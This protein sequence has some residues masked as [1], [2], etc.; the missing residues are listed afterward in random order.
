MATGRIDS[1]SSRSGK[2]FF[3][4]GENIVT[5]ALDGLLHASGPGERVR[6]DG[7]PRIKVILRGD[8]K[9]DRVAVISGGWAGHEPA[10]AGFVGAGMLTAAVSGEIFAS[11]QVEAILA[12]ILSVTGEPGCLVIVKNYTGDRLNFGLAVERAKSLGKNVA[13]VI[14]SDDVAIPGTR[15]PQESPA[16]CSSISLPAIL[17]NRGV[18]LRMSGRRRK[19][20]RVAPG[21]LGFPFPPAACRGI[22]SISG[23][24]ET[25]RS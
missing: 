20:S 16:P 17:L 10:H 4:K 5:D 24:Q 12:G 8:W 22:Q 25:R 21:R 3:N 7:Y 9:R 1:D 13:M 6:L 14:V 23:S 15:Q 2:R 18:L 11:P 19:R